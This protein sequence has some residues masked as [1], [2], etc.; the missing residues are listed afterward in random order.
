MN[1]ILMIVTM[2]MGFI[3]VASIMFLFMTRPGKN[4]IAEIAFRKKYVI[5]HLKNEHTGFEEIY[6]VIPPTDRIT[7]VGKHHYNLNPNYATISWKNRLHFVLNDGDVIPRYL[8]RVNTNEEIIQQVDET[9]TAINTRAYKIIYGKQKD[10]ALILCAVALMVAL[11]TAV[12]AIYSVDK[13]T[14]ALQ[15]VYSNVSVIRN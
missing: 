13:M 1:A 6:K 4:I 5:C 12:Y 2:F 9:D 8:D 15:I 10:I 11:L 3:V 7:L 14:T